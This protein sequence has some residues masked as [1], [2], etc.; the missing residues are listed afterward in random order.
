MTREVK[1][2]KYGLQQDEGSVVRWLKQVGDTVS[3]GDILC[4]IET[5]KAMFDLEATETGILRQILCEEGQTV[6]VLSDIAIITDTADE[7]IESSGGG[8]K[9]PDSVPKTTSNTVQRLAETASDSPEPTERTRRSPAA[10]KLANEL[11]IDLAGVTGTGPNGRITREDVQKAADTFVSTTPPVVSQEPV[12][13]M[14]KA[15]GK[16]MI[17]S[18]Q[19]IPHFYLSIDIDATETEAAW[20]NTTGTD[21]TDFTLTDI[22]IKAAADTLVFY[23]VLNGCLERD[24]IFYNEHVH[25][26]LAVGTDDGLLVPVIDN[27]DT[28]SVHQITE[29]R[30]QIVAAAR[31]GKLGSNTAATVTI[32]NLGM[33]GIRDFSAI[34]NP[35]ECAAL[36]I[37]TIRDEVKPSTN[38]IGLIARRIMTVTLSADHRLVDGLVCSR[39]LQDFKSRLEDPSWF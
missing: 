32:S 1:M 12:S 21:R 33:F 20:K 13:K 24:K 36:A 14:R 25:I 10:R 4:E 39:Y 26:G 15:I 9:H 5:D 35:P 29:L 7:V 18:K 30:S 8:P 27:A 2:P 31:E 11:N 17:I 3:E 28:K 23:P 22:I 6:P 34:I 37:G 19:T 16:A 38:P